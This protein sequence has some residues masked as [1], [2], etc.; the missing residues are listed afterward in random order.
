MS[1]NTH[2]V[3]MVMCADDTL[4]IGYAK[5]V[6]KRL[7]EHNHSPK[8]AKYTRGRRPVRLVYTTSFET[9]SEALKYEYALKQKKRQEKLLLIKQHEMD[10]E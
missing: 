8:G 6:K 1:E 3:Y 10:L 5:D 7:H 4:Y 9:L 2:F